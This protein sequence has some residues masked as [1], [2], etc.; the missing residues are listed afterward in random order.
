MGAD[1]VLVL[2][3]IQDASAAER[4]FSAPKLGCR[5]DRE[6]SVAGT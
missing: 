5:G 1:T 2:Y 3:E 6:K 4:V